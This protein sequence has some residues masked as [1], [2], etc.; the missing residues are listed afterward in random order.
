MNLERLLEEHAVRQQEYL[1]QPLPWKELDIEKRQ[2]F[3]RAI[4]SYIMEELNEVN[5]ETQQGATRYKPFKRSK[6][7]DEE[8]LGAEIADVFLYWAGLV[9]VAGF[10]GQEMVDIINKKLGINE[11]REDHVN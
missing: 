1:E 11:V 8:A 7:V 2:L 6:D 5:R 9:A 4:T 3:I 10:S